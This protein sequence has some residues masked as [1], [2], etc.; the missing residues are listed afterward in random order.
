MAIKGQSIME[1]IFKHEYFTK[2]SIPFF[3]FPLY[4]IILTINHPT[5]LS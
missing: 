3:L 1:R 2:E 4:T 5:A